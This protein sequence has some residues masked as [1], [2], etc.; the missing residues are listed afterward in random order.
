MFG[1]LKKFSSSADETLDFSD[2]R[3]RRN[4]NRTISRVS[5]VNGEAVVGHIDCDE[6]GLM[7]YD[8][9]G[10]LRVLMYIYIFIIIIF[11]LTLLTTF[12]KY[13]KWK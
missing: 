2:L 7:L 6:M 3:K 8:I 12:E 11:I 13:I 4:A 1:I 10:K 5:F 9:W